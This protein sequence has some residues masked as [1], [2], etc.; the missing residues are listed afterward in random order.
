[1]NRRVRGIGGRRSDGCIVGGLD[2]Q[3][4]VGWSGGWR[5]G[6]LAGRRVDELEGRKAGG[7]VGG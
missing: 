6:E 7:G 4:R 2:S 3:R 5:F 1:M